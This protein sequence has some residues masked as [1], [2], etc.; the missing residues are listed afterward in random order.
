M[1]VKSR[2]NDT[3][4]ELM[5]THSLINRI[6]L[7]MKW[8]ANLLV[9]MGMKRSLCKIGTVIEYKYGTL[10]VPIECVSKVKYEIEYEAIK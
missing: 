1:T 9:E 2:L 6:R 4:D 3:L 5:Y 7:D 10:T 8:F